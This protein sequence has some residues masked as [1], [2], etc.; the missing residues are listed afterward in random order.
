MCGRKTK[1]FTASI[2]NQN[3]EDFASGRVIYH[4]SGYPNFPVRLIVVRTKSLCD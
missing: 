3:F 2:E 4:R 1:W